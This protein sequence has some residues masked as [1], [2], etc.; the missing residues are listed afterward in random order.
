[1][2]HYVFFHDSIRGRPLFPDVHAERVLRVQ[3]RMSQH[4]WRLL[5]RRISV[6]TTPFPNLLICTNIRSVWTFFHCI[7][8]PIKSAHVHTIFFWAPIKSDMLL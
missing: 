8:L 5:L 1:M 7:Y 2:P 4:T 6:F 3:M